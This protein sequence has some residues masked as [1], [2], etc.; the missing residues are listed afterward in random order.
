MAIDYSTINIFPEAKTF[1]AEVT[2]TK[3]TLPGN[4]K[5]MTIGAEVNKTYVSF[6]SSL[7]DGAAAP[8]TDYAFI[9]SGVIWECNLGLGTTRKKTT[10]FVWSD[11]ASNKTTVVFE[12]Q[13]G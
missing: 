4:A 1:T 3:I 9:P 11:T 5:K 10:A 2:I 7:V 13:S 6:T 8:T 12:N